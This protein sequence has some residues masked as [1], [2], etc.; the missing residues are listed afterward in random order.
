MQGDAR[1]DSLG[2]STPRDPLI[3]G[4]VDC[5]AISHLKAFNV[6]M[7]DVKRDTKH[8]RCL[9]LSLT[10]LKTLTAYPAEQV[11]KKLRVTVIWDDSYSQISKP[12][13]PLIA[14]HQVASP[15]GWEYLSSN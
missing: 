1:P 3:S 5:Y 8:T 4:R 11:K 14:C 7:D 2:R 9:T 15:T 6:C 13:S 12:P 10:L